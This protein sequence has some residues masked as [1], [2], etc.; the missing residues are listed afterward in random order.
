[1]SIA[2]KIEKGKHWETGDPEWT[3]SLKGSADATDK[4]EVLRVGNRNVASMC[5]KAVRV[6]LATAH[7]IAAS[8]RREQG[9]LGW[10]R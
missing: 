7:A 2:V 4:I 9:P 6:G 5:A 10:M 1:M 3:V 8:Y